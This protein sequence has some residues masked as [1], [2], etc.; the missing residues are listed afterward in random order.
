MS[1]LPQYACALTSNIDHRRIQPPLGLTSPFECRRSTSVAWSSSR[2]R[3]CRPAGRAP[4]HGAEQGRC[5][6]AVKVLEE[7]GRCRRALWLDELRSRGGCGDCRGTI[8]P[9]ESTGPLLRVPLYRVHLDVRPL[10]LH[11]AASV[12]SHVRESAQ[13][14]RCVMTN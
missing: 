8:M 3:A 14:L 7:Q 4:C 13:V 1:V 10:E 9:R 12:H 5:R 2:I 6:I 11:F